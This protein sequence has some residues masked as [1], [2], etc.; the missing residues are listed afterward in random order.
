MKPDKSPGDAEPEPELVN[1]F[2]YGRQR[3]FNRSRVGAEMFRLDAIIEAAGVQPG[4][5]IEV[6]VTPDIERMLSRLPEKVRPAKKEWY[7]IEDLSGKFNGVQSA[8]FD[9]ID[10]GR[11][12]LKYEFEGQEH[13]TSLLDTTKIID[14]RKEQN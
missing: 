4:D 5:R 13:N 12:I 6:R 2:K 9:C 8:V 14:V 3:S 10:N 7:S 11:F 1:D